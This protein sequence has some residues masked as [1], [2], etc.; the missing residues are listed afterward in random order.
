MDFLRE[1]KEGEVD[2]AKAKRLFDRMDKMLDQ[3]ERMY[4]ALDKG[5]TGT[6]MQDL[7]YGKGELTSLKKHIGNAINEFGDFMPGLEMEMR[8]ED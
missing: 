6:M 3:L 7:G 4:E 2:R 5:A 1:L 8:G